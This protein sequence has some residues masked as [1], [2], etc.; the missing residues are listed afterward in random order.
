MRPEGNYSDTIENRT[1]ETSVCSAVPQSNA[2]Q[3]HP[4]GIIFA[5]NANDFTR[6]EILSLMFMR[7]ETDV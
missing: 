7:N 4:E 5:I 3:P 1:H 6:G 2:S